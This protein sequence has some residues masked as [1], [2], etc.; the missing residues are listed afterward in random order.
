[1]SSYPKV[2]FALPEAYLGALAGLPWDRPLE[3]WGAAGVK[4]FAVRRGN[5]RH[6]LVFPRVGNLRLVVKELSV[7]T[8]RH[9][10][11]VYREL[12]ERGIRTLT[13]IGWVEREEE[14]IA[15]A[16]PVGIQMERD[17][18]GL[19]VT[20][21]ER[22]VIPNSRI[23]PFPLGAGNR[24]R[25]TL[26]VADLFVDLHSNGVYWGDASPDNLLLQFVQ[27]RIPLIGRRS[28]LRALL[29]DAETVEL[30]PALSPGLRRADLDHF[31]EAVA[32]VNEDLRLAGL[33]PVRLAGPAD[34]AALLAAY[35]RRLAVVT[36]AK[37]FRAAT[38]LEPSRVLGDVS[39]P[40]YWNTLRKHIE[41]HRWYL[42]ESS[43]AAVELPAAAADWYEK[44][45]LPVCALFREA[46]AI[47]QLP[48]KTAAELYVDVMT[49]KY[50][51]S[52]SLG[53]DVGMVVATRDYLERFSDEAARSPLW[54]KVLERLGE[55]LRFGAD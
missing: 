6:P 35:Q 16:T 32:W 22:R 24:E 49:H 10:V 52:R 17:A 51:L 3:E 39:H 54:R 46:G 2:T 47:D 20:Q 28:R 33:D 14:P 27:M 4:S 30:Y 26:A 13:P 12:L 53:R 38:G 40:S 31:I 34:R 15:V 55:I 37:E 5:G 25:I 29:A 42:A 7:E 43:G 50:F 18:Y 1:M 44:V 23:Y 21:L 36:E 9:E 45:F 48:G 41:E 11:E 8:A 19:S